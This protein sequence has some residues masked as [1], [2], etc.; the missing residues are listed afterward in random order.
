MN[1]YR[2]RTHNRR[3][4]GLFRD[5]TGYTLLELVIAL[6]ILSA[7]LAISWPRL[8][9]LVRQAS[10]QQAALQLKDHCAE[11]REQAIQAGETWE[12]YCY[13]GTSLY[14]I[15]AVAEHPLETTQELGAAP[16]LLQQ[17]D[18]PPPSARDSN[19][20]LELTAPHELP[21]DLVFAL[22]PLSPGA[23]PGNTP[24]PP[25]DRPP[26]IQNLLQAAGNPRQE[27]PQVLA[28][29]YPDGRVTETAIQIML[30][31]TGD[32]IAI[33]L[34]GLTGGITIGP[35]LKA[36]PPEEM[37]ATNRSLPTPGPEANR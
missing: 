27:E 11:A 36:L 4:E 24:L 35:L 19:R 5:D 12:L 2:L 13:P 28:R 23:N 32:S 30:P 10:H 3:T 25:G 14:A 8:R 31:Q 26:E 21:D 15:R 34:R 16:A 9:Q 6:S 29:F 1:R 22:Q 37:D 18:L 7:L 33:R 20:P 17:R